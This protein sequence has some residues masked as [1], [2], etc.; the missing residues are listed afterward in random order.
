MPEHRCLDGVAGRDRLGIR[1]DALRSEQ[2]DPGVAALEP[3]YTLRSTRGISES[4][5]GTSPRV[6]RREFRVIFE[7]SDS[8]EQ[9]VGGAEN[10]VDERE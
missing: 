9:G 3:G 5:L 2:I 1:S 6:V 10:A 7:L 8:D 4:V